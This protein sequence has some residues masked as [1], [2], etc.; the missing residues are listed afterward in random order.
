MFKTD[1][2][3]LEAMFEHN[4]L[5]DFRVLIVNQT[6]EDKQLESDREN[7]RVI[8]TSDRGLPQ[9][10]NMAIAHAQSDI[11]LV[12][13]DDVVY[14]PELDAIIHQ[15]FEHYSDAAVI[16]FKMNNSD[17]TPYR[18]YP[19]V[20][21]H[22]VASADTVNGVVISFRRKSL[23]DHK[24]GYNIHFG[25]GTTFGTANEYVFMRN[26]LEA[27]LPTYFYPQAIL[28][29]PEFSSGKDEGSDRV[30]F[31]RAALQFKYNGF[32]SYLWVLKYVRFLK[33]H[34]YIKSSEI[35]HKVRTGFRG[36]AKYRSLLRGGQ[37]IR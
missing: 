35:S 26:C 30:V 36:I 37:E 29:H 20:T 19:D 21:A 17:G 28:S 22:N 16:T 12:A 33:T 2:S 6:D 10:R 1:L 18:S 32:W 23:L 34:G 15:A 5:S 27:G 13:D 25:L 11:C 9:S 7:V 4:Q 24:V 14:E 3:F 8:N 31:A